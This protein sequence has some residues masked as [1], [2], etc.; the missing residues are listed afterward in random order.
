MNKVDIL[1]A[2]GDQRQLYCAQQLSGD[3]GAAVMGFDDEYMTDDITVEKAD[4]SPGRHYDCAVLPIVPFDHGDQLNTP[5]SSS[6]ISAGEVRAMLRPDAVIFAGKADEH[7]RKAFCGLEICEYLKC[8]ELVLKNAVPTAEGVVQIAL[9]ELPVTLNGLKVLVVG[10]GRCG[11]II[12]TLLRNFGADVTAAVRSENGSAKARI[13]GVK[14]V[15]T[16]DMGTDYG[17]VINTAPSL[18]FDRETLSG[19]RRDTLFID[20]ASKPGG[21]D[22]ETARELGI[23]A[24]WALGIPGRTAPVT[25]GRIIAETVAEKLAERRSAQ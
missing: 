22:M 15:R 21:V 11:S 12:A 19:F 5:C 8:E 3:F 20:I 24:V 16:E 9:E 25:S 14:A 7:L 6:P 2:G 13:V 23:K 10:M 17:L 1:I 4:K 18:V